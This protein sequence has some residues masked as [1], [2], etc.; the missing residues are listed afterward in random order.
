MA[1]TFRDDADVI[2]DF[3]DDLLQ[4]ILSFLLDASEVAR[5]SVQAVTPSLAQ[6]RR[7]PLHRLRRSQQV[8]TQADRDEARG[9]IAVVDVVLASRADG[10]G[11]EDLEVSFF[12]YDNSEHNR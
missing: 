8:P 5:T 6:R 10:P 12:I 11:I 3:H 2:S 1:A 9:Q 4:R 7:P